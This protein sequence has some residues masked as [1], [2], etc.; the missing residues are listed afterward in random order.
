MRDAALYLQ[1]LKRLKQITQVRLDDFCDP[2]TLPTLWGI[3]DL[4][5]EGTGRMLVEGQHALGGGSGVA[6][7]IWASC[8]RS[9][10]PPWRGTGA[11][12]ARHRWCSEPQTLE[13]SLAAL[14]DLVN[15]IPDLF[16]PALQTSVGPRYRRCQA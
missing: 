8:P 6:N 4:L 14:P 1:T 7:G 16:R 10:S 11:A 13:A 15:Q 12:L 9:L 5:E 2:G 3:P